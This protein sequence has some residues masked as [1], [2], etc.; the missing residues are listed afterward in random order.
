MEYQNP[1]IPEGINRSREHP[2]REFAI[3]TV[4]VLGGLALAMGLLLAAIGWWAPLIPFQWESGWTNADAVLADLDRDAHTADEAPEGQAP[5]APGE[6]QRTEA[7]LNQLAAELLDAMRRAA[8]PDDPVGEISVRVHYVEDDLVNAFATLGGQIIIYEG[9]L[10]RLDSEN[11]V[12]MLLGHELAHIV[13]R[14]PLVAF[15]RSVGVGTLLGLIS[16]ISDAGDAVAGVTQLASLGFSR[17]QENRADRA[18]LIALHAHYGHVGGADELY[19]ELLAEGSELFPEF[20]SS[21]PLTEERLADL[22]AYIEEQGWTTDAQPE[23]PLKSAGSDLMPRLHPGGER[24]YYTRARA[25][26][27]S[28]WE[29]AHW[30][31]L[32]LQLRKG[33]E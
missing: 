6:R 20:L 2:L 31:Q 28:R 18:A 23:T 29:W 22:R 8:A 7:Y 33:L 32:L 11:A 12:A 16:G 26:E 17:Q 9:L 21:H 15:A 19:R 1:Q 24:L 30:P 3:L 4:G 27:G 13:H 10:Q 5:N 14:D 25:G